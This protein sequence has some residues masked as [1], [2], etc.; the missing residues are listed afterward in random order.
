MPTFVPE[1]ETRREILAWGDVCSLPAA[2]W[3][4][5]KTSVTE[6]L[7]AETTFV[8]SQK[9][10]HTSRDLDLDLTHQSEAFSSQQTGFL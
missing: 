5:N 4:L 9:E 8:Y 2:L 7:E 3:T 1:T 6:R 10:P